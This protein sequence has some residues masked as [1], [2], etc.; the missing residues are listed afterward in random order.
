VVARNVAPAAEIRRDGGASVL[1]IFVIIFIG[2]LLAI[3]RIAAL[4]S[5]ANRPKTRV[6]DA[7]TFEPPASPKVPD[8]VPAEWTDSYGNETE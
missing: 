4:T 8:T 2:L 3:S 1:V 7:T 6:H 5:V